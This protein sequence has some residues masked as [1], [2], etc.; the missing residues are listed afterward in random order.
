ML[1]ARAWRMR[2]VPCHFWPLASDTKTSITK[3]IAMKIKLSTAGLV[4]GALLLPAAGY[5]ADQP[6]KQTTTEKVK[7]NVSDATITAKIKT[8][9]AK[10]KQVDA[11]RLNVDTDNKG[12]VT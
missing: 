2:M 1:N 10:D 7:E 12:V 9:F 6:S 11:M 3:R 8:E 5:T 4:I